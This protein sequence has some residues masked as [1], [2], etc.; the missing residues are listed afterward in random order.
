MEAGSGAVGALRDPCD[1]GARRDPGAGRYQRGH[2]GEGRTERGSAP[3]RKGEG[4]GAAAAH[5]AR[6]GDRARGRGDDRGARGRGEVHTAVAR[7]VRAGRGLPAA[8]DLRRGRAHRPHEGQGEEQRDQM[9]GGR[10][11]RASGSFR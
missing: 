8:E 3:A 5:R 6:E 4:D 2:R 11:P 7:G 1:R 10:L 9:H